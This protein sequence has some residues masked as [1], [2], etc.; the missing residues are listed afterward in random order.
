MLSNLYRDLSILFKS[1]KC[2]TA[3]AGR[4]YYASYYQSNKEKIYTKR[5]ISKRTSKTNPSKHKAQLSGYELLSFVGYPLSL[6]CRSR[7]HSPILSLYA[8]VVIY[9]FN[10]GNLDQNVLGD[11]GGIG[12][13]LLVCDDTLPSSILFERGLCGSSDFAFLERGLSGSSDLRFPGPEMTGGEPLS[14]FDLWF[15]ELQSGWNGGYL[16]FLAPKTG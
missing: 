3:K 14:P 12:S 11:V 8:S 5:V 9:R 7:L 6:S 15:L 10:G 13:L 4:M 2:K 16:G 1:V